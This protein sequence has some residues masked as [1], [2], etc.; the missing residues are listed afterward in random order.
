VSSGFAQMVGSC[1]S[2]QSLLYEAN[3]NVLSQL[4]EAQLSEA[5]FEQLR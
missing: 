5:H 3:R 2:D 4:T 1:G